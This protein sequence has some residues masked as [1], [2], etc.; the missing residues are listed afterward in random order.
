MYGLP[1]RKVTQDT[2]IIVKNQPYSLQK[3]DIIFIS[4]SLVHKNPE[5]YDSPGTF[6]LTRFLEMHTKAGGEYKSQKT[7]LKD[8]VTLRNPFIYWGGGTHIVQISLY[9][10]ISSA[11]EESLR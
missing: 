7:T 10:L 6:R 3:D 1:P 2:T 4:M 9:G 11:V 8:G 5:I